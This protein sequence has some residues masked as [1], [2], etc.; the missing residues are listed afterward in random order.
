MHIHPIHIK[1]NVIDQSYVDK[2][3]PLFKTCEDLE[4]IDDLHKLYTIMKAISEY[5]FGHRRQ[6]LTHLLPVML[7]DNTIVEHIIH[8]DLYMDV[9]GMLE[10]KFDHKR[11]H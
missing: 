7:N 9:M 4:S 10:C 3:I 6:Y 8:D 1:L 11:V 2:L 5:F